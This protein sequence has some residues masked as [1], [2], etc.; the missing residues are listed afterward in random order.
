VSQPPGFIIN[1][2]K[3]KV[4]CLNKAFYGLGQAPHTWYA[5]LDASLAE[6][7]FQH[8]EVEHTMC[9]QGGGDR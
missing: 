7:G 8:G 5:K 9:T 2:V 3:D 1:R 6:L 4:L